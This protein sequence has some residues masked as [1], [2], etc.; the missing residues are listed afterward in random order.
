M[1]QLAGKTA[2][3]TGGGT[4]IGRATVLALA[5]LGCHV[6]V[7][8]R[9]SRAAAE[10]TAR[11]ARE[12]GARSIALAADVAED[13]ACRYLA[14]TAMRE[15]GRID[16]LINNAGTTRFIQAADLDEVNAEDWRQMM[17]INVMGAF[18]CA[19]AVAPHM[20]S[21]DGGQ[22]I[23][24]SSVS[25]LTG[26][27]SSIPYTASKA[28]LNNLTLSLART[29]APKIRVNAVA[30]GFV[31]GRWLEEGYGES[32]EAVKRWVEKKN[33]L[34]RVCSPEDVAEAILSLAAGSQLITGQILVCD[35]G[36]LLS[37]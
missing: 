8:Y 20:Q 28:A 3:V 37:G 14:T 25:S 31:T 32:Y 11:E 26:K 7:N 21:G 22:I 2:I 30:P 24:I 29:L 13:V 15:F 9:R 33:A 16:L 35:G 27:G 17:A 6:V 34:K 1:S 4:G 10:T 19:R 18:Q 23:N 12:L 36:T 5:K